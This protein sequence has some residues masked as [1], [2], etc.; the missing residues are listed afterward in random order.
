MTEGTEKLVNK[1]QFGALIKAA[2][3]A[4]TKVSSING[5]IGERIKNAAD[6]A[7]LHPAA[8][9]MILKLYRMDPEKR[10]AFLRNFDAYRDLASELNLFEEHAGDIDDLARKAAA[11]EAEREE[12][13]EAQVADNVHRLETGIQPLPEEARDKPSRRRQKKDDKPD[14]E[15]P[16][17][18]TYN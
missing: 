9:K 15:A 14:D 4:K 3:Q 13:E 8:F 6:N 18:Y 5:E 17:T 12:A 1:K 10:D 16:G 11:E 2:D 7:N